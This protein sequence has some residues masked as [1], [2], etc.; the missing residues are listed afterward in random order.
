MSSRLLASLPTAAA[1]PPLPAAPP[2]CHASLPHLA[3]FRWA[4]RT[5]AFSYTFQ[6]FTVCACVYTC[7]CLSTCLSLLSGSVSSPLF[8]KGDPALWATTLHRIMEE[9]LFMGTRYGAWP[10][11]R[12]A[13]DPALQASVHAVCTTKPVPAGYIYRLACGRTNNGRTNNERRT[14]ALESTLSCVVMKVGYMLGMVSERFKGAVV[15]AKSSEATVGRG[16]SC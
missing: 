11:L 3:R 15:N 10:A 4:V 13:T 16:G 9:N 12:A 7:V 5:T 8:E 14:V 2:C 1:L 6:Y